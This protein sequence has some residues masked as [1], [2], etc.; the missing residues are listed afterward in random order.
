MGPPRE[1]TDE[2]QVR[3]FPYVNFLEMH[4]CVIVGDRLTRNLL[5]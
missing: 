3:V 1:H 5:Q 4:P 2:P